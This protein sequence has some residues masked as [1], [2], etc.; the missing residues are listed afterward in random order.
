MA[1]RATETIAPL[2]VEVRGDPARLRLLRGA[3]RLWLLRAEVPAEVAWNVLLACSEA[4]T[5]AVRHAYRHQEQPGTVEL[6]ARRGQ[7]GA[8]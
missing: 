1:V 6:Q 5:N 2:R 8:R 4:C 3:L 7:S